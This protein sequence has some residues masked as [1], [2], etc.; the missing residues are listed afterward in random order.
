[1]AGFSIGIAGRLRRN[2]QEGQIFIPRVNNLLL[3]GVLALVLLFRTSDALANAYGIAVA[4]TM[5]TTTS[6]AFFV[7][8]KLWRWP[9]W[10]AALLIAA[11]L[12]IDIAFFVANLYKVLDGG[13]VPLLLGSASFAAMWTWAKGSDILAAKLHRDSIPIGDLLKMLAKSKTVRVTGTAVFLTND[14]SV[15]PASLMHNLKHNK[16]VHE[17]VVMMSVRTE[18]RPRV[19]LA[20]RYVI[21]HLSP[22]FIV[23]KLHYG[24]MEQPRI[25]TALAGLR[26]LGLKFDI[27]TTSFFI[28]RRSLKPSPKSGMPKWQDHLFIGLAKQA[29]SAPDFF[30]IPS[31]RVVELGAQ[32]KV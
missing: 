24:Y 11:F 25:P 1:V 31:D 18:P 28:S 10:R 7:V 3:G 20:E 29:A 14:V 8:W 9:L 15:A 19:P 2:P 5:V 17:R 23:V 6:L 30:Q 12:S 13:Y 4:G 21:E 26:K 22:D 32:M 27:M 16:V